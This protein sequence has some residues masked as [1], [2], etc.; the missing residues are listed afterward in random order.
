[1]FYAH[2]GHFAIQSLHI[3]TE[4]I[5]LLFDHLLVHVHVQLW[6]DRHGQ[7]LLRATQLPFQSS[8]LRVN[9]MKRMQRL[10]G[11]AIRS[12]SNQHPLSETQSLSSF[13]FVA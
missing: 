10:G 5:V 13:S 6:I 9:L 7:P 3:S 11:A 1:M 12:L 4:E 8:Q 2:R